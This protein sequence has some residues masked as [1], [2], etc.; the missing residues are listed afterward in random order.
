MANPNPKPIP[1]DKRGNRAGVQNKSTVEFKRAVEMA[2]ESIGGDPAFVTWAKGNPDVFY[3]QMFTK[4]CPKE[5]KLAVDGGMT[6]MLR[7]SAD[8]ETK[9]RGETP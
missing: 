8:L 9:L 7:T 3:G 5:I 1:A 2:Y 6:V 4:L